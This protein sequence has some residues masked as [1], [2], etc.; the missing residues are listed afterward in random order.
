MNKISRDIFELIEAGPDTKKAIAFFILVKKTIKSSTIKNYTVNSVSKRFNLTAATVKKCMKILSDLGLV[1]RCGKRNEHVVFCTTKSRYSKINLEPLTKL[2]LKSI[3][4]YLETVFF[5][6]VQ[7]RK[8]FMFHLRQ[9]CIDPKKDDNHKYAVRTARKLGI[10]P[11]SIF[12]WGTSYKYI[13]KKLS[14]SYN[15]VSF[16]LSTL[17][18]VG[19]ITVQKIQKTL[20]SGL[21]NAKFALE[22][23]DWNE[24]PKFG[25]VC[26]T[27]HAII[28]YGCSRYYLTEKSRE[29]FGDKRRSKQ[30]AA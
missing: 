19:W 4:L 2:N 10:D 21:E 27:K 30:L 12:D 23:M 7:K 8:D 17:E 29:I 14:I 3:I 24:L 6:E 25:K 16:I 26:A 18:R 15:K 11:K 28:Y 20:F 1:R 5:I 9:H 22:S 13:A